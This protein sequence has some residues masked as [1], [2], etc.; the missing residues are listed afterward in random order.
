M[1]IGGDS[2][3]CGLDGLWGGGAPV[4]LG[5]WAANTRITDLSIFQHPSIQQ[6]PMP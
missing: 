4:C 5:E 2:R 1:L 6:T 3:Y